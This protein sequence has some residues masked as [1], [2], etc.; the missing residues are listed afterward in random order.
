[1]IKRVRVYLIRHGHVQ[2]FDKQHQPVNPKYARLSATGIAQISQLAEQLKAVQMDQIFSS[3]MPRS[4]QTAQILASTQRNSIIQS[5]DDIREIK[6]GRLK[7]LDSTQAH[8]VIKKAYQHRRYA[9]D[10]FMQG[11]RWHEFE[12]RTTHWLEKILLQQADLQHQHIL[13]SSHDAV[14]RIFLNHA[15]GLNQKDIQVQEQNYACLN[16]LEYFIENDQII[17]TRILLQNFTAH[18]VLKINETH[19]ALDD[20]YQIYMKTN[21]FKREM[22]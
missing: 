14:N 11:E 9:L 4:I 8:I 15:H 18:N 22:I 6:S 16:I 21:G 3:T 20:V 17:E 10:T 7:E 5:C 13:V 12:A 2:Y 19:N 1:M